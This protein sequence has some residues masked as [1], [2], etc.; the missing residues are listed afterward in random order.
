MLHLVRRVGVSSAL[1]T[2][3][4]GCSGIFDSLARYFSG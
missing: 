3:G 1:L 4:G 2:G